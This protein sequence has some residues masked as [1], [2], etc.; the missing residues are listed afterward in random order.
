[1]GCPLKRGALTQE[2]FCSPFQP[3]KSGSVSPDPGMQGF[4]AV[5]VSMR[6]IFADRIAKH[7]VRCSL[8]GM[9][10]A[11]FPFMMCRRE[12]RRLVPALSSGRSG[13]AR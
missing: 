6:Y 13:T 1:M 9:H 8:E 4:A 10:P 3:V 2:Y 7:F 5:I 11:I 12:D